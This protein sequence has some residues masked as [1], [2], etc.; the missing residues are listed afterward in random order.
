M[1]PRE[2]L[3]NNIQNI[4]ILQ[5]AWSWKWHVTSSCLFSYWIPSL[6]FLLLSENWCVCVC[7][8]CG[9]SLIMQTLVEQ[10]SILPP[11]TS[12]HVYTSWMAK[13]ALLPVQQLITSCCKPHQVIHATR[14][15]TR[16][17]SWCVTIVHLHHLQNGLNA[18][19]STTQKSPNHHVPRLQDQHHFITVYHCNLRKLISFPS[20]SVLF[21]PHSLKKG[22][23]AWEGSSKRAV[24][25]L[26]FTCLVRMS[27]FV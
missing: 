7:A 22:N 19:H 8:P 25:S 21:F 10:A 15:N 20:L 1:H 5:G 24:A 12:P 6:I 14:K 23:K 9:P 27:G 18:T 4:I 11:F 3:Q 26:I 17:L 2:Y 13:R 16:T